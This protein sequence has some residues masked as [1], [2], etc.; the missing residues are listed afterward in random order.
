MEIK[1]Y[2]IELTKNKIIAIH[3]V[4]GKTK[5]IDFERCEIDKEERELL[6]TIV[7]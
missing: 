3:K 6:Q 5:D 7:R 4:L 2:N 1:S